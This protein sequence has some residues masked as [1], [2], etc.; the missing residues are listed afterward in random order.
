MVSLRR[1]AAEDAVLALARSGHL[2]APKT[3]LVEPDL[4]TLR[5]GSMRREDSTFPHHADTIV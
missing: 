2:G 5:A 4:Q 1:K 3:P